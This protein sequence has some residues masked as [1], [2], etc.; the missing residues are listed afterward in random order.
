[1]EVSDR[2]GWLLQIILKPL[3]KHVPANI[4]NTAALLQR[5]SNNKQLKGQIPIS[6]NVV[7]LYTNIDVK[8]AVDTA[9]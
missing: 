5:F 7:S 2:L 8:D 3:L 9:L 4:D 1:M 6:L